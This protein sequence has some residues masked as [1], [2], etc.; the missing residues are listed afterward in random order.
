MGPQ[1]A[2]G[3]ARF[4][5]AAVLPWPPDLLHA[6]ETLLQVERQQQHKLLKQISLRQLTAES[7]VKLFKKLTS[8]LN[9]KA[10]A[11]FFKILP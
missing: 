9:L 6:D 7:L 2:G 11:K 3:G 8:P 5:A 4:Q 10:V 1:F